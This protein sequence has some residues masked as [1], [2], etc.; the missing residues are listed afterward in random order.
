V[1]TVEIPLPPQ[2]GILGQRARAVGILGAIL[3]LVGVFTNPDQFYRSYLFGYLF[4]IGVAI[5]SLSL[6]MI[7]HLSG[8]VW[9]LGIRRILEAA[10]RTLFFG[11]LLFV[12]VWLGVGRLYSWSHAE[13]VASDPLV[14][15]KA[16]Y[17]NLPFF[18]ARA[19]FFFA[20][21]SLLAFFLSKWSLERDRTND[22]RLSDR[23]QGL[24]GGG[25]V[26]AGLTITFASVDWAMSL[27]P[28][29]FS[30]IYGMLFMIGQVLSALAFVILLIAMIGHEKPLVDVISRESVH[31]LGKLLLAFV[32]LWAYV[33]VSQLIIVWSANLPEEIPWYIQRFEGGWRVIAVVLILFH[34][35]L[36]FLMLLSRE[37]KRNVRALAL[38][39][40]GLLAVRL[41]DLY[42]L[43]APDLQ[44]HGSHG[45]HPHWLD[46]VAPA[47]IGGLWIALFERE[48]RSRPLL[49]PGDPE[50][51]ELFGKL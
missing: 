27:N 40:A 1:S 46:L 49:T 24:S 20:C 19:L 29:W 41:L 17:L 3:C 18:T 11:V 32:M 5:G 13:V 15:Q 43:I 42:W 50:L 23:L 6:L 47:A 10:S 22:P 30:T 31:D 7:H 4:W 16:A 34:F 44:G 36:P 51:S 26:L 21:W 2:I 48:L 33:G 8:G 12:P 9:G 35:A 39:A 14:Q 37:L 25:L 28:H 38:V 45:F